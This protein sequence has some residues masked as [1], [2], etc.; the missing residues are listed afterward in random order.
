MWGALSICET[1]K[2]DKWTH[3]TLIVI[4]PRDDIKSLEF[5]TSIISLLHCIVSKILH[6]MPKVIRENYYHV[7]NHVSS[8]LA[9]QSR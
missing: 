4:L 3:L 1:P 5:T 6:N 8:P 9:I 7:I 2:S